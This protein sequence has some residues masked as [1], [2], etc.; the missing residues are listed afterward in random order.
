MSHDVGCLACLTTSVWGLARGRALLAQTTVWELMWAMAQLAIYGAFSQ[1]GILAWFSPVWSILTPVFPALNLDTNP[2]SSVVLALFI[3]SSYHSNRV[4]AK[5][6]WHGFQVLCE[7]SIS[8]GFTLQG[9]CLL[10]C[11]CSVCWQ[12]YGGGGSWEGSDLMLLLPEDIG[13][14]CHSE[15]TLLLLTW[16]VCCYHS[17]C[18]RSCSSCC[19]TLWY[20]VVRRVDSV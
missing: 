20:C 2:L 6:C 5:L 10:G 1:G 11:L 9:P 7:W 12:V 14:V 18:C 4:C 16:G 13:A 19:Q 3:W 8:V 15:V 17:S